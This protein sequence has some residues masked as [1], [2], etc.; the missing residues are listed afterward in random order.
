MGVR[1]GTIIIKKSINNIAGIP[2]V[3]QSGFT[4]IEIIVVMVILGVLVAIA[5]SKLIDLEGTSA[6]RALEAGVMELNAR[7]KLTWADFKLSQ[8]GWTN[9]NAVFTAI[10][11][12]L[13]AGYNWI[14]GPDSSGGTFQFNS[15]TVVVT[16]TS[17]TE[18][19]VGQW[20]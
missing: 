7:E 14:A 2:R 15:K 10:D 11:R 13:G 8:N 3:K 17:S 5:Q 12:N 9:D 18:G 6:N 16:R 4:L 19:S 1:M 20:K